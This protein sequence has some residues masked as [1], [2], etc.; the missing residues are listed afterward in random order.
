MDINYDTILAD[1]EAEFGDKLPDPEK[2]PKRADY[3]IKLFLYERYL[4]EQRARQNQT[5]QA[6]S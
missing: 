6:S 3:Y 2:E 4:N 1:L 5:Q